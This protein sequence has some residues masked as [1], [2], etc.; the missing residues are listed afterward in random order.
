MSNDVNMQRAIL[1]SIQTAPRAATRPAP[2]SQARFS[3]TFAPARRAPQ[4]AGGGSGAS[5]ARKPAGGRTALPSD[6]IGRR[7]S[8][9]RLGTLAREGI[10]PAGA[11]ALG[12]ASPS[13]DRRTDDKTMY[14]LVLCLRIVECA[15]ARPRR[16]GSHVP[17]PRPPFLPRALPI[18][19]LLP[20]N[21]HNL[22]QR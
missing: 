12:P 4:A 14:L 1:A 5:A 19:S 8:T 11:G 18:V 9:G 3:S 2:V 15:R 20:D 21:H 6:A 7:G 13:K 16:G 17:L 10:A 22:Q